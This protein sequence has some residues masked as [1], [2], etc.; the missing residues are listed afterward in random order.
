MERVNQGAWGRRKS[1]GTLH[2]FADLNKVQL[3][4][5]LNSGIFIIL[6]TTTRKT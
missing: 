3:K 2:S 1:I 5:E 6:I 4:Q